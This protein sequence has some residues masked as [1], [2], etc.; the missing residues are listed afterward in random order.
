MGEFLFKVGPISDLLGLNNA[1]VVMVVGCK[2]QRAKLSLLVKCH[3]LLQCNMLLLQY[4]NC[5]WPSKISRIHWL[6][7]SHKIISYYNLKLYDVQLKLTNS[8][9]VSLLDKRGYLTICIS[10]KND[11]R[12]Y[13]RLQEGIRDWFYHLQTSVYESKRRRKFWVKGPSYTEPGHNNNRLARLYGETF[14]LN[15]KGWRQK[16]RNYIIYKWHN[17]KQ[18]SLVNLTDECHN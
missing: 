3:S 2:T 17:L 8:D 12:V 11:G 1:M 15:I 9:S 6:C 16:I 4:N 18:K 7:V 10:Q 5:N 13:L 14:V